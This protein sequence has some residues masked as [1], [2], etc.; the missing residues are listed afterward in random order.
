MNEQISQYL[1]E[2]SAR[3]AARRDFQMHAVKDE[4]GEI[5][6][7]NMDDY[8]PVE[9]IHKLRSCDIEFIANAPTDIERLT[10]LVRAYAGAWHELSDL[11]S[12]SATY[13]RLDEFPEEDAL[14]GLARKYGLDN[15]P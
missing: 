6:G 10:A 7:L 8:G 15:L 5:C 9:S 12:P 4:H 3:S 11:L 2:V 1:E 14:D 13:D